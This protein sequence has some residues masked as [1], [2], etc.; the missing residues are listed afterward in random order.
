MDEKLIKLQIVDFFLTLILLFFTVGHGWSGKIQNHN[1][2]LLS[3]SIYEF[4][5]LKF[6]FLLGSQG[7]IVVFDLTDINTFKSLDGWLEE[8]KK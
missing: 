2:Y 7:V 1:K 8:I 6:F 4:Q 3:R 5:I